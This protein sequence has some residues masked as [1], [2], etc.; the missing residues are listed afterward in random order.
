MRAKAWLI[1]AAASALLA[2]CSSGSG[3]TENV[4]APVA[5]VALTREQL[6][7]IRLYTIAPASFTRT[8]KAPGTVD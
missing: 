5:N 6:A 2:G 3:E 1:A 7:H 4:Q 8:V